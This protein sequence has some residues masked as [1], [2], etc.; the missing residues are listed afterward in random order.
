[1]SQPTVTLGYTLLGER[2]ATPKVDVIEGQT[3]ITLEVGQT[4]QLGTAPR[5]DPISTP[6]HRTVKLQNGQTVC[7][8]CHIEPTR[9]TVVR[10]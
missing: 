4:Y 1:M 2:I 10:L 5:H 9:T 8:D 3:V 7:L 6:P